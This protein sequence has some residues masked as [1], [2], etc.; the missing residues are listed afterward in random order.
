MWP[1]T[2]DHE[3]DAVIAKL[4]VDG[5]GHIA[6]DELIIKKIEKSE[7]VETP[8]WLWAAV[9]GGYVLVGIYLLYD[10]VC[11]KHKD[12]HHHD[13]HHHDDGYNKVDNESQKQIN[14]AVNN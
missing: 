6:K 5:D 11:K 7:P 8:M 13:E 1:G 14:T 3:I 12:D 2:T 4:D 10:K 9:A